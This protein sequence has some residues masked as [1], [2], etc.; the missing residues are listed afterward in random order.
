MMIDYNMWPHFERLDAFQSVNPDIKLDASR[1]PA[2][3]AW[4]ANMKTVPAVKAV[5]TSHEIY[6]QLYMGIRKGEF[7]YDLGL[8]E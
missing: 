7:D 4:I 3:T 8:E 5:I 1:F 2:L 6:T